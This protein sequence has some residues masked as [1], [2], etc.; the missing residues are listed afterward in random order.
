[1]LDRVFVIFA[2]LSLLLSSCEE[3]VL[4]EFKNV[5]YEWRRDDTLRFSLYDRYE[6]DGYAARIELRSNTDYPYRDV[7]VCVEAVAPDGSFLSIDSV[8]CPVYNSYG[9]HEG[10]TSGIIYQS[11][12]KEFDLPALDDDTLRIRVSH[13]MN[14]TILKGVSDVGIR[15]VRCGRH[16]FSKN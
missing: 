12:S 10:V 3:K 13:I 1:M 8:V 14:D 2:L 4:H 16:R 11:H 15:L 7:W 6:S 9:V 5:G